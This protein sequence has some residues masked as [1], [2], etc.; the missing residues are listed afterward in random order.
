MDDLRSRFASL[1]HTFWLTLVA[2]ALTTIAC[3]KTPPAEEPDDDATAARTCPE[4]TSYGDG[5]P[6]ATLEDDQ[7]VEWLTSACEDGE[8][9]A[10]GILSGHVLTGRGVAKDVER[11][12]ELAQRACD[13]EAWSGCNTLGLL[14]LQGD[15]TTADP[16]RARTFF[17]RACDNDDGEACKNLALMYARG[18]GGDED[19]ER[20]LQLYR[21]SCELGFQPACKVVER[22]TKMDRERAREALESSTKACEDG[23]QNACA[24]AG[25][26]LVFGS[27]GEP[28]LE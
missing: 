3:D 21:R 4:G 20:A 23:D 1:K 25:E 10:C 18:L 15:S 19:Q 8:Q 26:L 13:A 12:R 7:R 17:S 14:Y 27:A 11:A 28:D 9:P 5:C 2:A 22:M 16:E 24:R 6:P